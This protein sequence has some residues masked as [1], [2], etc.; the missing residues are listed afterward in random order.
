MPNS[1]WTSDR[2]VYRAFTKADEEY[3]ISNFQDA[4]A[5]VNRVPIL[6]RPPGPREV[7]GFFK[8]GLDNLLSVVVCLPGP[9]TEG[10]KPTTIPI[11]FL[12]LFGIEPNMMQ[13]RSTGIGLSIDAE[14][15]GKGYGSEA[16]QWAIYWG[17][18]RAGLH[19]IEIGAYEFNVGAVCD[20][21][22]EQK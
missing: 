2:L 16:I 5:W 12:G 8:R 4:E 14:Y 19:R 11:G 21:C 13:H 3:L 10:G 9:P 1:V 22:R 7:E 15:R 17:F 18:R 20:S 6:P